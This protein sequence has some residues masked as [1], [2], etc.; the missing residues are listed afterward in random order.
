MLELRSYLAGRWV[1]G[2]SGHQTLLN[3]ATEAPLARA[4]SDAYPDPK[5]KTGKLSVVD[6]APVAALKRPVTLAEIKASSA[7]KTF[8]L[9]RLPRL[10]VMPV[11]APLWQRILKMAGEKG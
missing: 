8:P 7:F 3:P 10:S 2:T 11:P 5:D 6:L 9:T 1:A 4:T